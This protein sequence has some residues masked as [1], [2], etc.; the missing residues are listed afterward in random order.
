MIVKKFLNMINSTKN[1]IFS[2]NMFS[3][4]KFDDRTNWK[5]ILSWNRNEDITPSEVVIN[6]ECAKYPFIVRNQTSDVEIFEQ[7]FIRQEYNFTVNK[8]PEVIVDAGANVGF[9]SIYFASKYP[10][11]K[12]IAI[13]PEE[14]NFR[15]L[16]KNTDSYEKM[17]LSE[18]PNSLMVDLAPK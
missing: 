8:P 15:L 11:S 3:K 7:I 16:K 18:C 2:V 9:A 6:H 17:G 14:S 1:H 13:E 10:N 5:N 4:S 12:I